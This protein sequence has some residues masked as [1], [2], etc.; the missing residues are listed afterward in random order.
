EHPAQAD[1]RRIGRRPVMRTADLVER[2]L[3]VR[4]RRELERDEQRDRRIVRNRHAELTIDAVFSKDGETA[5]VHVLDRGDGDG[6]RRAS[7]LASTTVIARTQSRVV[8]YLKVAAPAA[9]VATVPPTNAPVN[10]GA[11]G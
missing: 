9:L 6:V 7:P 3:G 5:R 8:P 2:L 4:A 10:V 11:G 1:E